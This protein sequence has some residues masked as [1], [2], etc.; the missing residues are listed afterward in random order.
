MSYKIVVHRK[1]QKELQKLPLS[2]KKQ[3]EIVIDKLAENPR[4]SGCKK[5]TE[6]QSDR[7]P[8]QVCYRLRQGTYRIVY[9]VEDEIVTIT[10]VQV[11][12]RSD[13]YR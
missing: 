3:V 5:L 12:H 10:V 8:N 1:A 7:S 13:V 2:V 9:T 4:P 11:Q 6:F